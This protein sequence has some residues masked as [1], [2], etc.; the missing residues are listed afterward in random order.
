MID[1]GEKSTRI[2]ACE[3]NEILSLFHSIHSLSNH[4]HH[5]HKQCEYFPLVCAL[6]VVNDYP[7]CVHILILCVYKYLGKTKHFLIAKKQ[8]S[9]MKIITGQVMLMMLIMF[10]NDIVYCLN[11]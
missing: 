5:H 11:V 9:E 6:V 7:V 10:D 4:H 3:E 8:K 1:I 2:F